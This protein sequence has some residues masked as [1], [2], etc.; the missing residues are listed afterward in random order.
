MCVPRMLR[1]GGRV[2]ERVRERERE[3]SGVACQ[4]KGRGEKGGVA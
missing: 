1:E 4:G 2:R 3:T